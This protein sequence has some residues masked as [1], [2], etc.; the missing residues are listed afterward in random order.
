MASITR[1]ASRAEIE[2]LFALPFPD[3]MIHRAQH[4]APPAF[5]PQHRAAEH[6][7]VDQDRRLPEDCGYCPQSVHY[8]TGRRGR[9][10]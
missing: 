7:A 6:A 10:S 5:R 9:A 4:R 8:D 2:A 1:S 3:L